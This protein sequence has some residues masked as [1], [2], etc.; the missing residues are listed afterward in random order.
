MPKRVDHQQRRRDLADAVWRVVAHN[1]LDGTS[2][3]LVADQAGW[4]IGSLRHYFASKDELLVF[5][6][7]QA[8]ERIEERIGRLPAS[9]TAMGRLRAVVAELLPLDTV[10]REEALVWLAFIA[11]APADPVLAPVAEDVW[12]QLHD[13]LAAR[14]T[15]A[16]R[17]GEV[18]AQI[19]AEREATRLHALIDGLAVHMVSAP[20]HAPPELALE[21]V[22][23]HL[24]AL[25]AGGGPRPARAAR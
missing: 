19:D 14:I 6:L 18:P 16:V 22:D 3:Q 5:A 15:E 8:G 2:L 17:S 11:R 7:G 4:S 12:R 24:E 10:R 20:R 25:R 23:H 21:V 13:P 1:G 9:G